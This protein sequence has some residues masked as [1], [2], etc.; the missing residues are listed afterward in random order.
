MVGGAVVGGRGLDECISYIHVIGGIY[1]SSP[2]FFSLL[3]VI[4]RRA[5]SGA[6][7]SWPSCVVEDPVAWGGRNGW[8]MDGS[9]M[10]CVM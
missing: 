4:R 7:V 3:G 5:C 1:P 6:E 2:P 9:C 8:K 10:R